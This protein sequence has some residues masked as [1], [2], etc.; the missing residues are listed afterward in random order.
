VCAQGEGGSKARRKRGDES[1]IERGKGRHLCMQVHHGD[2]RNSTK[3]TK[4]FD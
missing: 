1:I 2:S 3:N 4:A